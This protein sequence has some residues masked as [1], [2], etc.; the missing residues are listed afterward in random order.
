M[1]ILAIDTSTDL[2]SVALTDA[3]TV[4]VEISASVRARHGEVLLPH[5][6]HAL[7]LA[8][9]S[10][11]DLDLIA[12]G[13]GPGSFTG[14]RI[15]VAT[16]KG[17]ALASDTPL[18]GVV[19]LRAAAAA[20]RAPAL[21]APLFDAHKGEVF[22]ALYQTE[23]AG[24]QEILA[25]FHAVPT[26]VAQALREAAVGDRRVHLFGGGLRRYESDFRRDLPSAEHLARSLDGPRASLIAEAGARL[27]E[28]E[29][30]SPLEELEPLYLRPSDAKLPAKALKV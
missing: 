27:F 29:G 3:G 5:V 26:A 12:V 8:G 23:S 30:P 16:A 4:L 20:V 24:P 14:C 15:G 6:E 9:R 11:A 2:G 13:V 25:P 28:R 22:A 7:G 17:L 21:V 19:S 18:R 10:M 1:L